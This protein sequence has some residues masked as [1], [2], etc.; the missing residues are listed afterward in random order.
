MNTA[1]KYVGPEPAKRTFRELF[2]KSSWRSDDYPIYI[3]Y[4]NDEGVAY[5]E[6]VDG[7]RID[8]KAE[9]F[10]VFGNGCPQEIGS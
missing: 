7:F 2:N 8:H 6:R 10:Y 9:R 3:V 4:Q 1:V 5:E